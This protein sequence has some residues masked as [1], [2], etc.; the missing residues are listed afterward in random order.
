[1]LVKISKKNY[2]YLRQ[3][4]LNGNYERGGILIGK[5][6]RQNSIISHVVEDKS[7]LNTSFASFTR[8]TKGIW[9]VLN[10]IVKN[11]PDYDY[12]GEWHTHPINV[13]SIPSKIDVETMFSILGAKEYGYPTKLILLIASPSDKIRAWIF[14][15]NTFLEAKIKIC[16]II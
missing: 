3:A 4:S 7:S 8:K 14:E 11:F 1:M 15:E 9:N 5:F 16:H 13:P 6:T 10:N 12:I 2:F